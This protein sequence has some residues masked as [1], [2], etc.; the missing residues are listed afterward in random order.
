VGH[1]N[2]K[3][4]V[5]GILGIFNYTVSKA[6]MGKPGWWDTFGITV[7]GITDVFLGKGVVRAGSR[8]E[9][10][11]SNKVFSDKAEYRYAAV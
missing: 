6:K 7:G 10:W 11:Y 9:D 4:V 5:W 8:P 2:E 1:G 3:N